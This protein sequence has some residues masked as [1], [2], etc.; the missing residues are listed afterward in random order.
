M[1]KTSTILIGF[2]SLLATQAMS[3]EPLVECE[4]EAPSITAFEIISMSEY[5][6]I[7]FII[8][9][10]LKFIKNRRIPE[11][12][13]FIPFFIGLSHA[14]F[15]WV[16]FWETA[17]MGHPDRMINASL[18]IISYASIFTVLLIAVDVIRGLIK[19]IEKK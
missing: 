16:S 18:E 9:L 15:K 4:I 12:A 13:N 5:V 8:I 2:I 6:F 11:S 3:Q 19:P 17:V 1:K 10:I 7:S 14:I